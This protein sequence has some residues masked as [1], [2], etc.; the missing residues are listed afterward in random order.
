MISL[1]NHF[2][3]SSRMGNIVEVASSDKLTQSMEFVQD[4]PKSDV[5]NY[6][7]DNV[8][9]GDD[10]IIVPPLDQRRESGHINMAFQS[11]NGSLGSVVHFRRRSNTKFEFE[12]DSMK[13]SE[14]SEND[15]IVITNKNAP[16]Q[17]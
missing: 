13:I 8:S 5:K 3:S 6:D 1:H 16:F 17:D 2:F 15:S 7:F 12:Q 11:E 10:V 4:L 9:L 14:W